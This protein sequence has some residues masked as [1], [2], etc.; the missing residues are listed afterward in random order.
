MIVAIDAGCVTTI[1]LTKDG[2]I[3]AIGFD[4]FNQTS[5]ANKWTSILNLK[6]S[7]DPEPEN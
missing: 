2:K 4:E 6:S 5:I 3:I 7:P 1:G